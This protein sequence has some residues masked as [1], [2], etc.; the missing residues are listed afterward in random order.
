MLGF[1]EGIFSRSLKPNASDSRTRRRAPSRAP[2]GA[3]TE[4]QECAKD[5]VSEPPHDSSPALRT[6]TP[7]RVAEV[8]TGYVLD[9]LAM[10]VCSAPASVMILNVEPGGWGPETA[11]PARPSTSPVRGWTMATPPS[12]SPSADAAAACRPSRIVVRTLR[13]RTTFVLRMTRLPNRSSAPGRPPR[14]SS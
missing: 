2:S 6:L 1:A 10:P 12:R 9:G 4:L 13:P 5:T 8:L 3:N 7:D 11:S 14:R